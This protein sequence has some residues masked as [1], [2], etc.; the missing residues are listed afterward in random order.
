MLV[1][2]PAAATCLWQIS[3]IERFMV[4][5]SDNVYLFAKSLNFYRKCILLKRMHQGE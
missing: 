4:R 1:F 5:G 3:N 2:V